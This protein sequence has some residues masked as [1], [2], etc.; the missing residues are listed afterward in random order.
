MCV[1]ASLG[2]LFLLES[3]PFLLSG[4][5]NLCVAREHALQLRV[6]SEELFKGIK[7][8]VRLHTDVRNSIDTTADIDD[9]EQTHIFVILLFFPPAKREE[10]VHAQ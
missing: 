6:K 3:D 10:R 4:L 2:N 9:D 8:A 7:D 1:C 5:H